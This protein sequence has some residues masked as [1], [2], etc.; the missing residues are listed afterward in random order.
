M[1]SQTPST[2]LKTL[3]ILALGAGVLVLC[4]LC[5]AL[6]CLVGRRFQPQ[7]EMQV[8]SPPLPPALVEPETRPAL[9]APAA[10][11][12]RVTGVGVMIARDRKTHK[13]MIRGV[14]ANSPAARAGIQ[15]GTLFEAVDGQPVEDLRVEEVTARLTGSAGSKVTLDLLNREMTETN[16]LELIR[17]EFVNRSVVSNEIP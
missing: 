10:I 4:T 11:P 12:R 16:R 7:S 15:N 2:T 6:G 13:W 9:A 5:F 17:A 3:L 8:N 14:F 1:P